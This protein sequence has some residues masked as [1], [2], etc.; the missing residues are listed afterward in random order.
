MTDN[1]LRRE[2]STHGKKK[3]NTYTEIVRNVKGNSLGRLRRRYKDNI[4]TALEGIH[5]DC[6]AVF[7]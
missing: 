2:I 1:E 4:Q 3:R 6:L 5:W 7:I